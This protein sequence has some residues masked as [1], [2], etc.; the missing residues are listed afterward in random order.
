MLGEKLATAD[1][2]ADAID[3]Y[4]QLLKESPDYPGNPSVEAN[5]ML[6]EQK[7]ANTNAPAKH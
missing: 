5:L 2:T 1:R 4:K 6:L 7:L 3:N